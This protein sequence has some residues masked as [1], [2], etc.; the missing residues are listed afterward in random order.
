MKS[1]RTT[2]LSLVAAYALFA[3]QA[4]TFA[5]GEPKP[6][7]PDQ[8]A[9]PKPADVQSLAVFP[10]SVTLRGLDDSAQLVVTANLA[11]AK[12]QDLSGDV[13]YEIVNDKLARVTTSGR[14]LPLSNG[15]TEVV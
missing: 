1:L 6:A 14:I 13:K 9:L 5:Q 3:S 7:A 11:G 12:T 10:A 8:I 2:W 4:A 15:A